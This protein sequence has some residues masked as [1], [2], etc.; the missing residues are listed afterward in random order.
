M[1]LHKYIDKS[2]KKKVC[3]CE[4]TLGTRNLRPGSD[5][6]LCVCYVFCVVCLVLSCLLCEWETFI[7]DGWG[8]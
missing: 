5:I 6:L 1:G 4:I 2:E 3:S 8:A 7:V